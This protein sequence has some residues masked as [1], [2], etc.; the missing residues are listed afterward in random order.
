MRRPV[1]ALAAISTSLTLAA[2][3]T[4]DGDA[5]EQKI[6]DGVQPELKQ[7]KTSAQSVS[8]PNDVESETGAKFECTVTTEKD[9]DL[10]VNVKVTNGESGDVEY[11][12]APEALRQ[13]LLGS[14][15]GA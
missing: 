3:G 10:A 4:I 5:L 9:A 2:C 8:C 12:F 7:V 11:E 14:G 1:A 15:G 6:Q 13:L